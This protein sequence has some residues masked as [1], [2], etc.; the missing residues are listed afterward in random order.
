MRA[1]THL[2][3]MANIVYDMVIVCRKRSGTAPSKLWS[4]I[5]KDIS[6]S[7]MQTVKQLIENGESP[8]ELDT[9]VMTLGKCLEHYSKH[10]PHVMDGKRRVDVREALDSIRAAFDSEDQSSPNRF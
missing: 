10:Y 7:T 2:H 3:D 9:F 8:S 6:R 5:K 1:S 4:D